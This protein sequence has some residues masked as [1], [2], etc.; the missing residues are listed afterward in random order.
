[1]AFV[2]A[3]GCAKP[4]PASKED[5]Y[6]VVKHDTD[7]GRYVIRHDSV[8]IQATCQY[9]TYTVKGQSQTNVAYCLESLPVGEILKMVRGQGDR[10][11]CN[12]EVRDTEWQMGLRVEKEGAK[13]W[14]QEVKNP[15]AKHRS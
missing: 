4:S 6:I 15:R 12:W 5:S 13:R 11:F 3:V 2:L 9:S 10:L 8:E 14:G 7:G 1:M